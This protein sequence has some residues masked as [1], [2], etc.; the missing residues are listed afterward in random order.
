[1]HPAEKNT[2]NSQE[3]IGGLDSFCK[4]IVFSINS[5]ERRVCSHRHHPPRCT[6]EPWM[7]NAFSVLRI[8]RFCCEIFLS[9]AGELITALSLRL[10]PENPIRKLQGGWAPVAALGLSSCLG[11]LSSVIQVAGK[12]VT[13]NTATIYPK[14]IS[15]AM[16]KVVK[17]EIFF[18]LSLLCGLSV[19]SS[20]GLVGGSTYRQGLW[21]L[22]LLK[23]LNWF[24]L[25]VCSV[26]FF[27]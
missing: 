11:L 16:C 1:M 18:S 10:S 22:L 5:E 7:K 3:L 23:Q 21:T 27:L 13:V 2:F 20:L 24:S 9:D 25:P 6:A 8:V 15:T 14:Y 17:K 12:E 26:A 4:I 19:L